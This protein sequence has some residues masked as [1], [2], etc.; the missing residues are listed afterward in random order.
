MALSKKTKQDSPIPYN[1]PEGQFVDVLNYAL[2]DN[3]IEAFHVALRDDPYDADPRKG[4][5][6]AGALVGKALARV[7]KQAIEEALELSGHRSTAAEVRR[8]CAACREKLAMLLERIHAD[9]VLRVLQPHGKFWRQYDEDLSEKKRIAKHVVATFVKGKNIRCFLQASTMA[10]TIAEAIAESDLTEMLIHTN[11][12]FVPAVLLRD[13]MRRSVYAFCGG[14]Y[15]ELCGGWLYGENDTQAE[16]EL[17]GLFRRDLQK[18]DTAFVMPR[19]VSPNGII[20][21]RDRDAQ[22]LVGA[23]VAE[24]PQ[25]CVLAV[26][27]RVRGNLSSNE[28]RDWCDV[29]LPLADSNR[30][31]FLISAGTPAQPVMRPEQWKELHVAFKQQGF[32]TTWLDDLQNT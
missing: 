20:Y 13:H 21:Y 29:P 15:D 26:G 10:V 9:D 23:M 5:D 1:W 27:N 32:L 31:I 16:T 11:S 4:M 12:V 17:R 18:L 25:I 8:E 22:R 30:K 7:L 24:S 19:I 2:T 6:K 14:V 28:A 3:E